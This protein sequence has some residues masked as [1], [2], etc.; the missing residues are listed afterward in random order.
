MVMLEASALLD[1]PLVVESELLLEESP[2][3]LLH[4]ANKNKSI[5][6]ITK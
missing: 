2:P 1:V 3:P 6:N 5:T 4:P